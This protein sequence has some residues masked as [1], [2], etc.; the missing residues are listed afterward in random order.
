[1][2]IIG[3][4]KYRPLTVPLEWLWNMELLAANWLLWHWSWINTIRPQREPSGCWVPISF[5][6][7]NPKTDY[8][9]YLTEMNWIRI[10][11]KHIGPLI[12]HVRI[13]HEKCRSCK[14]KATVWEE[15][16]Q[17]VELAVYRIMTVIS[18]LPPL[19]Y[20]CR[21]LIQT[22]FCCWELFCTAGNANL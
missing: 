6:V 9:K 12:I 13:C 11:I 22:I 17:C 19:T 5:C 1:M 7:S 20:R 4:V 16:S 21:I 8:K 2:C 10:Q 3:S 18:H 15:W 14:E